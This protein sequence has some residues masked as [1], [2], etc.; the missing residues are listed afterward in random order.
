MTP[1]AVGSHYARNKHGDATALD[2][3]G[4]EPAA[5][6]FPSRPSTIDGDKLAHVEA[7]AMIDQGAGPTVTI[8]A[9]ALR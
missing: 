8:R 6:P 7:P 3:R 5:V 9:T 1:G 2:G 4:D